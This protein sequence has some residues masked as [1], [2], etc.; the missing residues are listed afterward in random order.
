M[1]TGSQTQKD[2]SRTIDGTSSQTEKDH[3]RTIDGTRQSDRE[4]SQQNH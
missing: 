1:D 3:S 4:G 2:H